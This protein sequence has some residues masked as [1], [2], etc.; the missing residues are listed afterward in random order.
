MNNTEW[1]SKGEFITVF[2]RKLFVI[3]SKDVIS[4][5]VEKSQETMV[6]LHGYPTSSFDYFKVL[7]A[8]SKRYRVIIHD[9]LGFGFSDKPL[10]YSY[11]LIEQA[12]FALQLWKQLGLTKVTLLAHDY[13]TS[14][15]TEIL[16]RHNKKQINLQI[17][18]F[19]LCNGSAHIELS[20]LR[21]IQ[22]L[23]KSKITGKFVARLTNYPIFRKNM[24]NI[25]FDKSKATNEELKEMWE[26]LEHNNGRKVIHQLTNY[27]NERYYYWHRWIGALK[28]TQI[29]AKI[30]WAKNDPIAIPK[31]A[32]L[33]HE[34]IPNNEL[35]WMENCGHFLMLEKPDEWV[36][37]VLK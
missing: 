17:D 35:I 22:K 8:L 6:V 12:D 33:L 9:H 11:S 7:P 37:L 24:R 1:K 34:E 14:V 30:I 28:E 2:N 10:D 27:I 13:G 3:D 29:P 20:K 25:Y 21:T 32:E 23:L 19:I 16:A 15:A 31:I 18:K 5:V 4:S 26:L 36:K